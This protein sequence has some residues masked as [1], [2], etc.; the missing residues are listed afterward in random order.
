[1]SMSIIDRHPKYVVKRFVMNLVGMTANAFDYHVNLGRIPPPRHP[2]YD[3]YTGT[4]LFYTNA[5][6]EDIARYFATREMWQR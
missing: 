1:M 2:L 4:D 6:V 3:G 5:E